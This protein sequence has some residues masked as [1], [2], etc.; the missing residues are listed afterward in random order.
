MKIV[1]L[2]A[3]HVRRLNEGYGV[4]YGKYR[5]WMILK[6]YAGDCWKVGY[7]RKAYDSDRVEEVKVV[8]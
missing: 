3:E 8:C 7:K 4:V 2:P 5:Y 6:Q 1:K